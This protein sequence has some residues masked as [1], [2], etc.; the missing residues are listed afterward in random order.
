MCAFAY[1]GTHVEAMK[2]RND[3][4]HPAEWPNYTAWWVDDDH[5]PG[6]EE[7]AA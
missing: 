1:R 3:W 7:A 6:W 5:I 2:Y 4:V